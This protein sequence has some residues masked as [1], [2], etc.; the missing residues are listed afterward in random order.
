VAIPEVFL[1]LRPPS[2]RLH[3]S[4]AVSGIV[5][6]TLTLAGI[7]DPPARGTNLIRHSAAT[8]MLRGG[9]TLDEVATILRH[10]SIDMS[11]H[12]AKVDIEQLQKLAQPWPEG[13]PC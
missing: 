6:L 2:G 7:E 11:A 1:R 9:A 12:Y 13:G 4:S 5:A 3:S 8:A 10:R